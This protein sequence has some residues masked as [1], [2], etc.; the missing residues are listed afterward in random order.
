MVHHQHNASEFLVDSLRQIVAVVLGD[1]VPYPCYPTGQII[2]VVLQHNF[3]YQLNQLDCRLVLSIQLVG[4]E[5]CK[6]LLVVTDSIAEHHMVILVLEHRM[7]MLV[8]HILVEELEHH[9]KM[10]VELILVE[11]LGNHLVMLVVLLD[12]MLGLRNLPLVHLLWFGF[13]EHMLLL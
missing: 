10:L 8:G 5:D 9:M 11:E 13:L 7:V 1:L 6:A 2:T 12:M 3:Y 4:L